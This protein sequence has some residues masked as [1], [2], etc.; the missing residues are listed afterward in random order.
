MVALVSALDQRFYP[1]IERNWDDSIFRERVLQKINA[2]TTMLDLGAGAGIVRQMNFRSIARKVVGV[3]MDPRVLA[4]PFLD[5]AVVGGAESLPFGNDSF[6]LVIADNVFEHLVD[7]AAVYKEIWRTL[8]PGGVLMF[9]TPNKN[10]YMPLIARSTPLRFHQWV[11]RR[12]GRASEDSF[13][14]VYLSNSVPAVRD[15]ASRTGFLVERIERIEGRPEYLRGGVLQYLIGIAYERVVNASDLLSF[16]RIL[17][18]AELKK[19]S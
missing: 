14:T 2:S 6:D 10:H 5:E 16:A 19:P 12:R 18:I 17:L 15:L 13:H 4:N 3:D 7:P 9:K 8:R 1:G 11:N